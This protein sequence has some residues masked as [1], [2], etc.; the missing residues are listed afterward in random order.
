M[1]AV[2]HKAS[3]IRGEL[4]A[5]VGT[6]WVTLAFNLYKQEHRTKKKKLLKFQISQVKKQHLNKL[7]YN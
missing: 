7:W 5:V 1:T 6:V 2:Q 3:C 4:G